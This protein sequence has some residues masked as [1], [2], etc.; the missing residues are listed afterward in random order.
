MIQ[1]NDEMTIDNDNDNAMY[2]LHCYVT[3]TLHNCLTPTTHKQYSGT[4]YNS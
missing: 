4:V 1:S 3:Y 2:S